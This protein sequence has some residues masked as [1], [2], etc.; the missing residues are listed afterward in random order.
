MDVAFPAAEAARTYIVDGTSGQLEGMFSQGYWPNFAVSPDGAHVYA[1]DTYFEKHTRGKRS[2]YVVVRDART[3]NVEDDIPLPAGRLLV[4]SK[5][6]DFGVT[7][8]GRYGLSFNLA[9]RTAISV[10]DL[11]E[12]R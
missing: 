12:R 8:D 10:V 11:K 5:K 1:A 3:L 7:P 6:Y 9:P 4:V 2:D